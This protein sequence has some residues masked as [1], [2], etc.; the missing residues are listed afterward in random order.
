MIKCQS[1]NFCLTAQKPHNNNKMFIFSSIYE[2]NNN[3]SANCEGMWD[4][5]NC[6]PPASVGDTVSQ[7]C[8]N[9]EFFTSEGETPVLFSSATSVNYLP[10]RFYLFS[11]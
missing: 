7:P 8:P 1:H 2:D 5:L 3:N 6:W 9:H 10:G 11:L 4:N